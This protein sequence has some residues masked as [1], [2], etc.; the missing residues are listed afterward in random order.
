MGLR[1]VVVL[2]QLL[3]EAKTLGLDLGSR[4]LLTEYQRKRRADNTLMLAATDIL[5]RLFSNDV[6]PVK[7]AR[8]LGLGLVNRLTPLKRAF[9]KNA[10]GQMGH[11]PK[12]M[13]GERI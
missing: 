9:V 1:D 4:L 7:F 2:A 5:N 11:V 6:P 13:R 8:A 10:M 12:L 3:G